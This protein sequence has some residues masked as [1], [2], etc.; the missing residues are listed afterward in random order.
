MVI[1]IWYGLAF[2]H[3]CKTLKLIINILRLCRIL[4]VIWTR[5]AVEYF[6][7]SNIVYECKKNIKIKMDIKSILPLST[8]KYRF[9]MNEHKGG[10]FQKKGII[11]WVSD[12]LLTSVK[13]TVQYVSDTNSSQSSLKYSNLVQKYYS[14]IFCMGFLWLMR[15]IWIW[16]NKLF[17]NNNEIKMLL[18]E[19]FEIQIHLVLTA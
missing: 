15:R 8:Q 6:H 12:A 19:K 18:M 17:L 13:N 2:L 16:Y 10:K 7:L 11:R 14:E 5:L 4:D 3:V 1:F 9:F